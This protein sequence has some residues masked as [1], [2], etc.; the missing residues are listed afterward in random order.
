MGT[1]IVQGGP[2]FPVMLPAAYHYMSTEQILDHDIV[3]DDIPDPMI[4]RLFEE[5]KGVG[6][7]GWRGV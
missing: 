2:G 7:G 5:V 1:S 4:S 6:V 3:K